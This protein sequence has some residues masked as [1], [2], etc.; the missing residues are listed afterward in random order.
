MKA[1]VLK[2]PHEVAVEEVEKP[3]L[4]EPT[5]AVLR[6]E[7]TA[8]CGTDLHPFEGRIEL[9]EDLVLGH[10]FLG[11]IEEIGS[12]VNR[13]APGDRAVA[14]C[15]VNGGQCWA[16]RKNQPG[17][18][19][20]GRIFGMGLPFG[21][22]GGGQ[23]EYVLV[24]NADL[25]LRTL[26]DDG[27]GTEEDILFVGDIMATGYEA[28]RRALTPGDVVAVVGA[29]PVGLCSTMAA[30]ALGAS[31]VIVVDR[32]PARLTEAEQ[33]GAV[34]VNADTD[35][36]ADAVMDL[37]GSRGADVVVDA[38][39]HPSAL[40]TACGLARPGGIISV[41]GAYTEPSI[42]LPFGSLWMKGITITGGVANIVRYM[43]ETMG[44]ISAG[45]LNPS[46]IISHRMPLSK[47][48]DAYAMF[49]AR[50]ATKIILDPKG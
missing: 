39:G 50:E 33:I 11:T 30:V 20:S 49:H 27:A 13:V 23:A 19:A 48:E 2:R 32:V 45:K 17:R 44:L 42:E 4:L 15:V 6:V 14:S 24:P 25:V 5:D 31:S 28:V 9:G 18:C 10:E 29:G 3:S 16:C 26:P 40:L 12:A 35:D 46:R 36:P 8:I 7:L 38:V 37:T 21:G 34:G 41:P 43:D 1:V 22:L 47:A